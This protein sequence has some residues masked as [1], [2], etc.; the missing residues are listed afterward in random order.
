MAETVSIY[1]CGYI[2]SKVRKQAFKIEPLTILAECGFPKHR[3][4]SEPLCPP[5]LSYSN[6][7]EGIGLV[8][9]EWATYLELQVTQWVCISSDEKQSHLKILI[10]APTEMEKILSGTWQSLSSVFAAAGKSSY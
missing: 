5:A 1:Y 3:P 2:N 10:P 6:S 7:C 8:I 4:I 9:F